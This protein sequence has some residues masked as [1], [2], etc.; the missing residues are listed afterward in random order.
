MSLNE[1]GH[2]VNSSMLM[3]TIPNAMLIWIAMFD[4]LHIDLAPLKIAEH[5][6]DISG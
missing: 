3:A 6:P 2:E 5:L 1:Q 4:G